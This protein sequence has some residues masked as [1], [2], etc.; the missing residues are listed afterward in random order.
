MLSDRV[1]FVNWL[2]TMMMMTTYEGRSLVSGYRDKT[3]FS[4]YVMDSVCALHIN[5]LHQRVDCA[6][7]NNRSKT[8]RVISTLDQ[9]ISPP[10][11]YTHLTL[12]T[13]LR[14]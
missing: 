11:S 12:P 8:A 6:A 1:V 2:S 4:D 5:A 9:H 7:G 3:L 13:I 10:V 14:V